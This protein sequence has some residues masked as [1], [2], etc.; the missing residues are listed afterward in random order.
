MCCGTMLLQVEIES[1]KISVKIR[2][3]SYLENVT[4]ESR[5][6]TPKASISVIAYGECPSEAGCIFS[7]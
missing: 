1:L 5:L 4:E 7:S 3:T 2:C 6:N